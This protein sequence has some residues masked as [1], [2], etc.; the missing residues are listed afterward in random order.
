MQLSVAQWFWGL[1]A[2]TLLT[3]CSSEDKPGRCESTVTNQL[4]DPE[5]ESLTRGRR[6][7]L[8]S[9]SE[10]AAGRSFS[11]A[12]E[13]GVL[14]I[15]KTGTEPWGIVSQGIR[16]PELGGRGI[17]YRAEIRLDMQAPVP[18]HGFKQ[19]GGLTLQARA[20]GRVVGTSTLDH[21][22]HMGKSDWV[23][24]S[25]AMQLPPGVNY[26]QA[27]ILH[28]ANGTLQVRNPTLVFTDC[29]D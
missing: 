21:E 23:P 27:G 3:A 26:V 8:W 28:Q 13:D 6:E 4:Q 29:G 20:N 14:T 12:L 9:V 25:V 11:Y 16:N 24:V 7:R 10:H 5:F 17:A 15:T 22:P 19:G 1:A 18:A 2:C